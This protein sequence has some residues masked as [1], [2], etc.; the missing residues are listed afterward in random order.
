MNILCFLNID[1]LLKNKKT[2]SI[3]TLRFRKFY[4]VFLKNLKENFNN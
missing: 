3:Q 4:S 2:N 1:K